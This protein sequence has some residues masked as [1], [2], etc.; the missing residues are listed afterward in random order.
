MI[1]SYQCAAEIEWVKNSD[2]ILLINR[3][4]GQSWQFRGLQA[5]IWELLSVGHRY[6]KLLKL[7]ALTESIAL[8]LADAQ[9]RQTLK[10][11]AQDGIIEQVGDF[12]D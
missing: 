1:G 4:T 9:I 8:D 5:L 6:Q 7:F 2:H 12:D 10:I 11:W 3:L